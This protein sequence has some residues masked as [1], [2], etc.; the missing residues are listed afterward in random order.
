[1]RTRTRR[2]AFSLLE[3][4]IV[5]AILVIMTSLAYPSLRSM[6]GGYNMVGGVDSMRSAWAKARARA[7][8]EGRPYRVG[9]EMNGS[10]Y[11]IAPDHPEFWAGAGASSADS[12]GQGMVVEDELPGGVRF[13]ASAEESNVGESGTSG[14][15]GPVSLSA[16]STAVVFLPD[17]TAREDVQVYFSVRGVRPRVLQLRGLTGAS[18]VKMANP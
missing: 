13:T 9:I 11:R 10:H 7:I 2:A 6:S 16:Y 1:M 3:T 8:E 17:G 5:L 15:T 4:V 18:S 12:Q 14:K